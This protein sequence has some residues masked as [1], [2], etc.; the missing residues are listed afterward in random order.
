VDVNPQAPAP[1]GK[2]NINKADISQLRDLGFTTVQA[3]NIQR[4]IKKNGA[5][6]SVDDLKK[7]PGI[8][9][10]IVDEVKDNIT[11]E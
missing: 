6:S 3:Q 7:V 5:L 4:Y 10:D 8:S 1:S 9:P 11:A 2:I